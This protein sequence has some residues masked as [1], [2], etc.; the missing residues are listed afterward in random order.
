MRMG[1]A[2]LPAPAL[3]ALGIVDDLRRLA[4]A[5]RMRAFRRSHHSIYSGVRESRFGFEGWF[6]VMAGSLLRCVHHP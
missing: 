6:T 5:S 4:T 1:A 3:A 2:L